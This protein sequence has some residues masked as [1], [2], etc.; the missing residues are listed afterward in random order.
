MQRIFTRLLHSLQEVGIS[1]G[2]DQAM[3]CQVVDDVG[4]VC[5]CLGHSDPSRL[6]T[7]E[8]VCHSL[9]VLAQDVVVERF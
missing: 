6:G 4:S 7:V 8:P 3:M 9:G 5:A 1:E 2:N